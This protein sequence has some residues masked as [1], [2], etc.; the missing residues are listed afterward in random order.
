[1]QSAVERILNENFNTDSHT[2]SFSTPII[3]LS[4]NEGTTYEGSFDILGPVDE[5]VEG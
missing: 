1:M 3:E 5:Y 4:V 2:L